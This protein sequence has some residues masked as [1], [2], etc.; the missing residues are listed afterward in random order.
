MTNQISIDLKSI[1]KQL[2]IDFNS[3]FKAYQ[4]PLREKLIPT[5]DL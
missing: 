5:N 3:D 1:P 4:I 2:Y